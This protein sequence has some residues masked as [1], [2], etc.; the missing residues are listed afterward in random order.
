[1]KSFIKT[2][3][4][5]YLFIALLIIEIAGLFYL[6]EFAPFR[7]VQ[8]LS[9]IHLYNSSNIYTELP[10]NEDIKRYFQDAIIIDMPNIAEMTEFDKQI[11]L[12]KWTRNNLINLPI[13][14]SIERD[15][16]IILYQE[17]TKGLSSATCGQLSLVYAYALDAF[18]QK[19]RIVSLIRNMNIFNRN[20]RDSHVVAEVWSNK[21]N[22]WY[23][24]DPTFNGYFVDKNSIPLNAFEIRQ[25]I[26]KTREELKGKGISNLAYA[27]KIK[28]E[29]DGAIEEPTLLSYYIDPFLIYGDI[30]IKGGQLYNTQGFL[31]KIK[32]VFER[33][34]RK[35]SI[36]YYLV[37]E[38]HPPLILDK[39]YIYLFFINPV[40]IFIILIMLLYRYSSYNKSK[41]KKI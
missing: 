23:V 16:P 34:Y 37:D 15:N 11:A 6:Y 33:I 19:F 32:S 18:R 4:F 14:I 29:R 41:F 36:S 13:P 27:N 10:N 5:Q 39:I 20:F 7:L 1:M 21:Y 38:Y 30:F 17:P 24:S 31:D 3:Y 8:N 12:R 25:A 26:Y 40:L 35:S 2:K 9:N 28:F 22:K